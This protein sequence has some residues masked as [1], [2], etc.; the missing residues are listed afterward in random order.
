MKVF[1]IAWHEN[2]LENSRR[3]VDELK[4]QIARLNRELTKKE[5]R[6]AW[7]EIQITE[8]KRRGLEEFDPDRFM[9]RRGRPCGDWSF[10]FT[11]EAFP[12]GKRA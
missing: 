12:E 6:V 2:C 4:E 11:K 7:A 10:R 8:A 5:Q 3:S 9:M 1:S